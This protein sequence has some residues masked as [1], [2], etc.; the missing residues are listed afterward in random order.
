MPKIGIKIISEEIGSGAEL[1]KG[2]RVRVK[3]DIQLNKGD[4]LAQSQES[5]IVIGN[6]HMI[7]GFR[8]GLEGIR[9]G[10]K[11]KYRASPHLC[12]RDLELEKIP[13]NAVLIFDVKEMEI[14]PSI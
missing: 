3:Y 12:Y 5:V 8:Y 13:K 4:Y 14:L 2:D 7:A 9:A 6:R 1:K 10:G 11:R